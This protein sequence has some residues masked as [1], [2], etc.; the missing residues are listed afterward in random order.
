MA[1]AG[2][3]ALVCFCLKPG[4]LPKPEK[5]SKD[6]IYQLLLVRQGGRVQQTERDRSKGEGG[7]RR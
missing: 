3:E 5:R 4:V 2:Q 6:D 7:K 1:I